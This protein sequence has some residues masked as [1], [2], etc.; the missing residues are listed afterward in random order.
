[1]HEISD[2]FFAVL[3][4]HRYLLT[5]RVHRIWIIFTWII[6]ITVCIP[7]FFIDG[8]YALEQESR[9]CVISSKR[10]PVALYICTVSSFISF[11]II[12]TVYILI[13]IHVH[14]ST[15]R[16][17]AFNRTM[18][19]ARNNISNNKREIKLMKKMIIQ[20]GILISGGPVFLFLIA[21][22]ATQKQPPPESLY[23]I[24]FNLMTVLVSAI[25]IVQ[26]IMSKQLKQFA[27]L[28][29]KQRQ[30]TVII[31]GPIHW[32]QQP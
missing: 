2:L 27:I 5:W 9:S 17:L 1:M 29:F 22:H 14:R 6:G 30:R 4:K 25:T 21:W 26:F 28:I 31:R 13:L 11:S 24:G 10:Y 20:T 16:V 32:Q 8:D 15:R 12:A 23:L 3:Y 19:N 18:I 7:P